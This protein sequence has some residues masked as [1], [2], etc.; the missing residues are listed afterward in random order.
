MLRRTRLSVLLPLFGLLAVGCASTSKGSDD[1]EE[2]EK[3]VQRV[4]GTKKKGTGLVLTE[5]DNMLNLWSNLTA[6]GDAEQDRGRANALREDLHYR[7]NKYH[8]MLASELEVGPVRNRMIA[9][10]ALGFSNRDETLSTLLNALQDEDE[11]VE[12]NAMIG[13]SILEDPQTPLSELTTR[14]SD[15]SNPQARAMA[16]SAILKCLKAGADGIGV[17]EHAR[18][19]LNDE[20]PVVRVNSCLI[21][22]EMRNADSIP[23]IADL[24]YDDVPLVVRAARYSTAYIAI[25]DDHARGEA[26]RAL[27]Q[28]M[29]REEETKEQQKIMLYL[30]KIS[31]I[32]HGDKVEDW[33]AWADGL[34]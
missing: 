5:F 18:R 3:Y 12:I 6:V 27:T 26:A 16:S 22:A 8:D 32:D 13:L 10:M 24:L 21:L 4:T 25:H 31:T 30:K 33:S 17:L 23:A 2:P 1:A 11:R 15:H 14:M 19:G 29:E 7:A 34:P 20:E 9:A 28:A